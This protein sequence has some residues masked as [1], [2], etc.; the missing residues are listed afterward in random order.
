MWN[1]P[2]E[3]DI[4]DLFIILGPNYS[5]V[6][7]EDSYIE[8]DDQHL[9]NSYDESNMFNIFEHQLK[10]RKKTKGKFIENHS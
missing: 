10:L 8:E 2:V 9:N 6:S 3:I 7:N 1:S 5:I 4:D